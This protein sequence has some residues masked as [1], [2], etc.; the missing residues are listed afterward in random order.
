MCLSQNLQG[1]AGSVVS[2]YIPSHGVCFGRACSCCCLLPPVF[3]PHGSYAPAEGH[4]AF[5]LHCYLRSSVVRL[6]MPKTPWSPCF[7]FHILSNG[8]NILCKSVL[9]KYGSH[10][11]SE[12][13]VFCSVSHRP[14]SSQTSVFLL[15]CLH[16]NSANCFILSLYLSTL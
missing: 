1:N 11:A 10:R 9:L 8:G 6:L 4:C 15:P 3:L 12:D 7:I 2:S 16:W 14:F 13:T 5:Q